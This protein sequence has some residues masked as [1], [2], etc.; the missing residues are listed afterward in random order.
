[1][2][3][4]RNRDRLRPL[5]GNTGGVCVVP[6]LGGPERRLTDVVC[7]YEDPGQPQWT[8]D[9]KSLILADSCVPNGP[10]RIVIFAMDRSKA[11]LARTR[12]LQR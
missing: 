9:G 8:V 12:S 3:A 10:R 11:L 4:R 6:A 2:V 1:M 7:P 5:P